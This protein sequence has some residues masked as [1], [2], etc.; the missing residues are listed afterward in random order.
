M[1]SLLA[2]GLGGDD[3]SC[4]GYL[5]ASAALTWTPNV[6]VGVYFQSET[7]RG[8]ACGCMSQAIQSQSCSSRAANTSRTHASARG[9]SACGPRGSVPNSPTTT[10]NSFVAAFIFSTHLSIGSLFG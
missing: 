3:F 9:P 7:S 4:V 10:G 5:P 6:G 2:A 1:P 8:P